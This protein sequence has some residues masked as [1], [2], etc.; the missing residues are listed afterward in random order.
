MELKVAYC[1]DERYSRIMTVSLVSLLENNK[2]FEVITIYCLENNMA[3]ETQKSIQAIVESYN[4]CIIFVNV[5]KMCDECRFWPVERDMMFARFLLPQLVEADKVLYLDCDTMI[6][7][8]LSGLWEE[9]IEGFY[10]AVVQDTSRINARY[11]AG[12]AYDARYFNSGMMLINCSEWKKDEAFELMK[13]HEKMCSGVAMFPDQR[14]LNAITLKK[15]KIIMPRYNMTTDFFTYPYEKLIKVVQNK[16]FYKEKDVKT[17]VENPVVVHFS[18]TSIDRPWFV[19]SEHPYKAMYEEYMR[20]YDFTDFELWKDRKVNVIKL[21]IKKKIPFYLWLLLS[22]IKN[23]KY[24]KA[25][26]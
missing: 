6:L 7:S 11:E 5:K 3:I 1:S 19:E 4:R 13:E 23:L 12:I 2:D 17:S 21:K 25:A 8:D 22:R 24:L 20:M 9:N 26:K 14:P 10:H 15:A 18:G 16:N